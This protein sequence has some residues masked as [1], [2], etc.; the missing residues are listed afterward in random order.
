[1]EEL[2]NSISINN[3]FCTNLGYASAIMKFHEEWKSESPFITVKTS[4]STGT[5]KEMQLSKNAMRISAQQTIDFFEVKPDQ[6]LLMCL[7]VEFIA[8]K[9]IVVRAIVSKSN[10]VIGQSSS[11]PLLPFLGVKKNPPIHFAAFTPLQVSCILE[12][13]DTRDIFNSIKTII[14]GGGEIPVTLEKKLI[15]LNKNI[16]A[17]YGM[18]E[19]ITHIA[20]RKIDANQSKIY[21]TFKGINLGLDERNCLT[22]QAT[23]LGN[24]PIITND[25]VEFEGPNEFRF[26][27]RFD[28]VINSGGIKLHPEKIEGKINEIL[29]DA[30]FIHYKPDNEL[31]QKLVLVIENESPYDETTLGLLKNSLKDILEKYEIPKEII[32]VQEF[33]RTN[34]GK[35]KR[36]L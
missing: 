10:L 17:T 23:Y 32:F 2:D 25:I 19:T 14:I 26:L 4:G 33:K 7:P 11:N 22:I 16:Y 27:G 28:N 21:K 30:F 36:A 5:P 3:N 9:M 24:K 1:M 31:G 12:D 13:A 34:T 8:G 18:T 6:N 15:S 20:V 29:E 35:I